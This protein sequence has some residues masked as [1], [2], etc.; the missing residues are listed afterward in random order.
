MYHP[1]SSDKR[2]I[3]NYLNLTAKLKVTRAEAEPKIDIIDKAT[4]K[5]W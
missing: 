4:E 2:T 5:G 3:A 1:I